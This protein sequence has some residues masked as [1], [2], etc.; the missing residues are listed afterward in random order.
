M[1]YSGAH[2]KYFN[3]AEDGTGGGDGL[4]ILAP[5]PELVKQSNDSDDYNDCSYVILYMTR[6]H[7]IVFGGDSHDAAWE[8][9]LKVH[10]NDVTNVDLLIAPHHGRSSSRS[11]DFLDVLRPKM[12]FFG[13]ANSEHLAYSAWNYRKLPFITN[14]QA[15]CMIAD[16]ESDSIKI[17]VTHEPFAKS[18]NPS[19][20]YSNRFQAYYYKPI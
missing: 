15:G 20:F 14:N 12:T 5:T 1:L 17:Y 10:R 4:H 19:T 11:Y 13:N 7:K 8:H 3:R 6:D 18:E 2:G 16:A 9:I